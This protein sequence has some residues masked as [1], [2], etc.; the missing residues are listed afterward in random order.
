MTTSSQD[1]LYKKAVKYYDMK[2]PA[3]SYAN[4]AKLVL[5]LLKEFNPK[6]KKLLELACGTGN[7]TV[8]FAKNYDVKATDISKD[9]L[10]KAKKKVK[11]KFALLPM[12]KLNE[13]SAYDIVACMWESFRYLKSYKSVKN[14]LSRINKAL[15]PGGLFVVDFHHFPP[16]KQALLEG[17]FTEFDGKLVKDITLI[18]TRGCFDYRQH[19]VISIKNCKL[20]TVKLRRSPLL[21]ISEK[22]MRGFLSGAG[23]KVVHFQRRFHY[24]HKN[25]MLFVAKRV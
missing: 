6:A 23:F 9:V 5:S 14:L 24:Y 2:F 25:S 22:Q 16:S 11:A 15:R 17:P 13:K 19:Y 3:K 20:N 1:Q 10:A 12:E 18:S 4:R 8:Y 21:R 7:Y